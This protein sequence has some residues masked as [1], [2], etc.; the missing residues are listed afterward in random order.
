L[1][2][3]TGAVDVETGSLQSLRDQSRIVG[4]SV[5]RSRLVFGIPDHQRDALFRVRRAAGKPDGDQHKERSEE[6]EH[7]GHGLSE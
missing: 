3:V 5:Q 1:I 6:L 7:P 2:E 4:R